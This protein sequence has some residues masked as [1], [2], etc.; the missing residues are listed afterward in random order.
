MNIFKPKWNSKNPEKRKQWLEKADPNKEEDLKKIIYLAKNDED[1]EIRKIA[2][3]FFKSIKCPK[4]GGFVVE[5]RSL[6]SPD[7]RGFGCTECDWRRRYC[8]NTKCENGYLEYV[9]VSFYPAHVQYSCV[10]CGWVGTGVA[11]H[12]KDK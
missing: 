4:C 12:D 10:K 5:V 3:K 2:E 6:F 7:G 8:G 11:F 9:N 1:N